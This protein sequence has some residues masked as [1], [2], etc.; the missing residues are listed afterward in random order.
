MQKHPCYSIRL[1]ASAMIGQLARIAL[2][3]VAGGD[4]V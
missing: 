2:V 1:L 4:D 3:G